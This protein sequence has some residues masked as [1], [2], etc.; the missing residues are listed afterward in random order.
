MI[1]NDL[2]NWTFSLVKKMVKEGLFETDKFD[3]KEDIPHRND[4]N[5]KNR[6]CNSVCAFANTEGGFLVFGIKDDRR[7]SSNE[8]IIGID[9]KRD[10]PREFGD[11]LLKMEPQIYY[12]FQN[13]PIKIPG[14]KK[15]I[16]IIKIP[17]SPE[18]PHITSNGKFYIRTNRGNIEMSYPQI[19]DSF[20]N[21]EQ[22]RQKMRLFYIELLVIK[23]QAESMIVPEEKIK[24]SYSLVTLDVKLLQNLLVDIYPIIIRDENLISE[25]ISIREII[26][27]I[28]NKIKIFYTQISVPR[29]KMD[30][31]VEEH[32]K[33]IKQKAEDLISRLNKALQM[34]EGELGSLTTQ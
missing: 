18:R 20:I 19:K 28:D 2:D 12:D 22:R 3:F 15:V 11:K 9:P 13:P 14:S 27:L 16:H 34:I 30:L 32:N 7:L 6:M 26:S 23:N 21:E 24:T 1:P 29:S 25:I 10:F 5:G 17:Q 4:K 8:R 31:L 33:F